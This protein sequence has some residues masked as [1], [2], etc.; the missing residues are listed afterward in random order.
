MT[1]SRAA[2]FLHALALRRNAGWYCEKVETSDGH[3]N[4]FCTFLSNVQLFKTIVLS[5]N[6]GQDMKSLAFINLLVSMQMINKTS[7][8]TVVILKSASLSMSPRFQ[9]IMETSSSLIR[10]PIFY[11]INQPRYFDVNH[12][13]S[14]F[15]IRH[16]II[17]RPVNGYNHPH[18]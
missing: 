16:N 11:Q 13:F 7:H 2:L 18:Q 10:R 17:Q 4:P 8:A 1:Q 5:D 15:H 3:E 9:V 14:L 12:K 6:I